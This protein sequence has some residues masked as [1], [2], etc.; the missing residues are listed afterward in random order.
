MTTW[1]RAP[2]FCIKL[3][4]AGWA[5]RRHMLSCVENLRCQFVKSCLMFLCP[6]NNF[7]TLETVDITVSVSINQFLNAR[8]CRRRRPVFGLLGG[9]WRTPLLHRSWSKLRT[10]GILGL[11]RPRPG[12]CGQ[13]GSKAGA[14]TANR[15]RKPSVRFRCSGLTFYGHKRTDVTISFGLSINFS[16]WTLGLL[17]W[18]RRGFFF[19]SSKLKTLLLGTFDKLFVVDARF[20]FVKETW[21][22][23]QFIKTQNFVVRN[24]A[25]VAVL[26]YSVCTLALRCGMQTSRLA[27]FCFPGTDVTEVGQRPP[28]K[29]GPQ[30]GTLGQHP[31][32]GADRPGRC[33]RSGEPR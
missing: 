2:V 8:N 17:S 26:A 12:T 19:N 22:F 23:F 31:F 16:L 11:Q 24:K 18:K 32:G 7:W 30:R 5:V 15:A 10:S 3:D 28:P 29:R 20:A 33:R 21:F 13:R 1:R 27:A 25:S 4:L 6:S 9:L 14:S